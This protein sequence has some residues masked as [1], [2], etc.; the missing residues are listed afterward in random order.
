MNGKIP[1]H[2]KE[3]PS[4]DTSQST[5]KEKDSS[6]LPKTSSQD[7]TPEAKFSTP[8]STGIPS[9]GSASALKEKEK[10]DLATIRQKAITM[11]TFKMG[12]YLSASQRLIMLLELALES[13]N[14]ESS[15]PPSEEARVQSSVS[16]LH[17]LRSKVK[18]CS[19]LLSKLVDGL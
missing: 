5:S 10:L 19:T 9:P 3:V 16:S 8:E 17:E 14:W 4:K 7:T 11:S 2:L 6:T 1:S 13:E 18:E 12:E 15:L